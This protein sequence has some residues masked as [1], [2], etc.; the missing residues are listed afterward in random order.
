[1][2]FHLKHK[3]TF[4]PLLFKMEMKKWFSIPVVSQD[5]PNRSKHNE[6]GKKKCAKAQS[7]DIVRQWNGLPGNFPRLCWDMGMTRMEHLLFPKGN[8]P[9]CTRFY[10]Q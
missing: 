5:K 3:L 8:F 7:G 4:C 6:V 10:P 9:T 1:M 2:M